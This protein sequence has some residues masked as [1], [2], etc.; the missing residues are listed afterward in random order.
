MNPF[1]SKQQTAEKL[2]NAINFRSKQ[3]RDLEVMIGNLN[4]QLK[5]LKE[6]LDK[7]NKQINQINGQND[8][9]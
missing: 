3:I 9:T 6:S 7:Y 8:N 5:Q 1:Q 2:A 4:Q